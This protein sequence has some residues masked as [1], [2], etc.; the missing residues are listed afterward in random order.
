[1]H[2]IIGPDVSF[3]QDDPGTP[4][5]ID[6]ARMNQ[7][8]N[9]VIVRARQNQWIDTD[10]QDNWRGAKQSGLPRGSYW[11]Y[12]SRADPGRQA[13]LWVDTFNGDLGELPL[14]AD[15]GEACGGSL[16]AG[17]IGGIFWSD[18][19]HS[20][21]RRISLST[22]L[23]FTGEIITRQAPPHNLMSSNIFIVTHYGSQIMA[24][25][26]PLSQSPGARMNGCSGSSLPWVLA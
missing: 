22:R 14:F 19:A 7:I 6:F 17:G 3:Y 15:I 9:F 18:C 25:L 20:S 10:F 12:D 1:M 16:Q 26:N 13:E 21:V 2:R 5:G 24:Q 11:F 4:R 8:T 23:I